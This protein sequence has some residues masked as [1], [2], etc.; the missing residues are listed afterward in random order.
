LFQDAWGCVATFRA[1][2]TSTEIPVNGTSPGAARIPLS[3]L[4]AIASTAGMFKKKEIKIVIEDG[5]IKIDTFRH[6]HPDIRLGI[7]PD[8]RIDL[9]VDAS[10]LDTLGVGGSYRIGNRRAGADKS[11]P[12]CLGTREPRH[13]VCRR[14][15]SSTWH[16]GTADSAIRRRTG[17]GVRPAPSRGT[18]LEE[19]EFIW[20]APLRCARA[21]GAR[22]GDLFVSYGTA[23]SRALIRTQPAPVQTS[24][25]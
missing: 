23:E 1:V 3:A 22:K 24:V 16:F 8:Q 11:N 20:R 13:Y 10:L 2:G 25:R 7:L 6:N 14:L 5:S 19:L 4:E 12:G 15:T 21:C 9:P 18:F 17:H